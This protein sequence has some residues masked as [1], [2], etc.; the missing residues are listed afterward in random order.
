VAGYILDVIAE[1]ASG[2]R[3]ARFVATSNVLSKTGAERSWL[4]LLRHCTCHILKTGTD[5]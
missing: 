4:V 5:R 3:E 2:S 1:N